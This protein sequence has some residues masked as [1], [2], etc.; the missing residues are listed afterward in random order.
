[1]QTVKAWLS[2][3]EKRSLSSCAILSTASVSV[4]YRYTPSLVDIHTEPFRSANRSSGVNPSDGTGSRVRTEPSLR[5]RR[6][7]PFMVLAT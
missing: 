6:Q 3:S 5:F 7:S 4:L 1:M 2:E